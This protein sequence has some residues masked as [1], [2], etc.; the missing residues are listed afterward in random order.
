MIG[1]AHLTTLNPGFDE[2]ARTTVP[3]MANWSEPGSEKKCGKC[4]FWSD[5]LKHK[6]ARRCQKYSELMRG[7][8]GPRVP[9]EAT[10]C[11][12]FSP[13]GGQHG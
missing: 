2:K 7:L 10:A 6:A 3:D 8:H 9:S 13:E 1:N 5:E 12:Y 11:K 4:K